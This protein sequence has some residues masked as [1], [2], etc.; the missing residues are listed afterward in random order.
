MAANNGTWHKTSVEAAEEQGRGYHTI[1]TITGQKRPR[2]ESA[3]PMAPKPTSLPRHTSLVQRASSLPLGPPKLT[4]SPIISLSLVATQGPSEYTQRREFQS[5]PSSS[6]DPLLALAHPFYGLPR[7]LVRN[8]YSLVLMLKRVLEEKNSKALLVL[9][10]VALVQEKVRWLRNIVQGVAKPKDEIDDEKRIWRR[11]ADEDTIRVIGFFGG[12]KIKSTWSDFEI[13]ANALVNTAIDDFTIKHLKAVV[14]DE[15]HMIDD[16]HRGY[17]MEL[18]GTKLLTLPQPV[19][20]IGMS[21]TMSNIG[22][23]ANWLGAHSYETRYRPVP[24]EE[25]LV[26][27]GNVYPAAT[28]SEL[29]KT[30]KNLNAL[31]H[32]PASRAIRR[33]EPSSHKVFQDPVLNAVVSLAS[34]TAKAGYGALVFASSRYGCEADARWIA[35][36]MPTQFELDPGLIEKRNELMAELR[37]LGTGIDPVLEETVPMGVAFHQRDIIANAYDV[38]TLKVFLRPARR[39]ILHNARMGRDFVGPSMLR[40]MRGRAGR[41]GKDEVGETYLCC[42]KDDLEQVIDLMHAEMPKITSG[43]MTDKQR[44]QRALLEVIAIRLATSRDALDEYITRTLLSHSGSL[45]SL[46]D[47]VEVS[48]KNLTNMGFVATDACGNYQPTKLGRAI[49]ASALDPD[50]GV[51]IHKELE[52]ALQAFVMDGEMHILYTFTPIQDFGTNINWQVFRNEMYNLDDSGHRVLGFLGLKRAVINRLYVPL[53]LFPMSL[54]VTRAQGSSLKETT[55]EEKE[56]VRV[57][58][59]FYMAFQLRDLCNEMPIHAVARKYDVPRGAVQTLSQTCNGFAAGMI[60]FCEHMGWG[61]MAAALDH[62]SDRLRAGAKADLLALAQITF[63]KS[64]TARVFWENGFRSIAAVANADPSELL[65]ILMQ[66]Q[67]SKLRIKEQESIKYEEKLMAKA[68]VISDSAN[69]LWRKSNRETHRRRWWNVFKCNK[70]STRRNSQ[71]VGGCRLRFERPKTPSW[72]GCT[73]AVA[74]LTGSHQ[75]EKG[76]TVQDNQTQLGLITWHPQYGAATAVLSGGPLVTEMRLTIVGGR[77]QKARDQQRS[78]SHRPPSYPPSSVLFDFYIKLWVWLP[79]LGLISTET[80]SYTDC[81]MSTHN[82]ARSGGGSSADAD[83][84]VRT[85]GDVM[86]AGPTDFPHIVV[87]DETHEEKKRK[88]DP[89]PSKDLWLS[90]ADGRYNSTIIP[91]RVGRAPNQEIFQ[92]HRNILL[93]TGYFRK[94]LCGDFR[95]ADAQSMD[96]PEED[97]AIFHFLVAFLYQRSFVPIRPAAS[98]LNVDASDPGKAQES[99]HR[100][101]SESE[102]SS[103]EASDASARS[104]IRAQR[105]QRRRE[106]QWDRM[107]RKQPG[108]H[109]PDCRCPRCTTTTGPPCW[110][111][112]VGRTRPMPG[113]LPPHIINHMP[114]V[115]PIGMQQHGRRRSRQQALTPPESTPSVGMPASATDEYADGDR[116]RGQDMRTFLLTY[117]LSLEVYIVANKFLMDDFKTVIQ[118]HCIDMLE[119]AGPDAAQSAVLQLCSKLYAGVPDSDPLLRM[120]FARVGFLQPLLWQRAPQYTSEFLIGHPEVAALM[121][122]ETAIRREED[123]GSRAL[124]SMERATHPHAMPMWPAAPPMHPHMRLPPPPPPHP[125]WHPGPFGV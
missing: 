20:I 38:G 13:A 113:H 23:L 120:I 26:Y 7:S 75:H 2:A 81:E 87:V 116:I 123:L 43:L 48:L 4:A 90:S 100:S 60:K 53:A 68:R 32:Q 5:T 108:T 1:P 65:P 79:D 18:M 76:A 11:R 102:I 3:H 99:G 42:R 92:V 63:V 24:I 122:R 36:V 47:C 105:R 29:L 19:Q 6:S 109:R 77:A 93:T 95:E 9:P 121:L 22:L 73:T 15:L 84:A 115:R 74:K 114:A 62:F 89:S 45:K 46:Q 94:A 59:R 28:T 49:V 71:L 31:T 25:H 41:K 33:I 44:I 12:S 8:F 67:P 58:R 55:A 104:R 112:G 101:E 61:V 118:R 80:T 17:L 27:E 103:S 78:D 64:R 125:H 82:R 30:A 124:P 34:E 111:C 97:P 35:K 50:D 96:F 54:T 83:G 107:N 106:R 14:L 40:Q 119:S 66:A 110:N 52:R 56:I 10:Y 16:D 85:L 98:A 91:L 72:L 86:R 21:A 37:S 57:H 69:R 117:E 51:F 88:D 70:K 39:V